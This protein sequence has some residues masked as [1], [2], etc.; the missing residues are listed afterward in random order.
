VSKFE[1]DAAIL[2]TAAAGQFTQDVGGLKLNKGRPFLGR[3]SAQLASDLLSEVRFSLRQHWAIWLALT[4]AFISMMIGMRAGLE[5]LLERWSNYPYNHAFAIFGMSAWLAI[6]VIRGAGLERLTPSFLGALGSFLVFAVY[7]GLESFGFVLG[8]Q[9]MLPLIL[10]LI[11]ASIL[12]LNAAARLTLPILF[13]YFAIPVWDLI[14]P[15]LQATTVIVVETT[16]RW[17][18]FTAFID[19]T[20]IHIP[21]GTFA[22]SES[23]AGLRY[24]IVSFALATFYGLNFLRTW[25]ASLALIGVALASAIVCNW[26]R[27]YSLV[28]IG[29]LTDMQHYLIAV[30]HARY[31]WLIYALSLVPVFAFIVFLER[32]TKEEQPRQQLSGT[33][34]CS[35]IRYLAAAALVSLIFLLPTLV[36]L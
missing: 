7:L 28:V 13:L 35:P 6:D 1:C 36:S 34:L 11:T 10:L 18:G 5:G 21:A 22:V 16:L 23:C 15:P 4:L 12:G 25:A 9:A 3:Q 2:D 8:M 20:L 30:S 26:L 24:F 32:R 14:I 29:D 33:V 27:V 19:N 31:G 17:T